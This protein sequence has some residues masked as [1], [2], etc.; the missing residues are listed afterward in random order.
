MRDDPPLRQQATADAESPS[1]KRLL[2]DPKPKQGL[3]PASSASSLSSDSSS[4]RNRKKTR[5]LPNLSDCHSCGVHVNATDPKDR[6]Q[7]LGSVWRIV[8]LCRKCI[9]RVST[10][11]T[12]SYC[13]SEADSECYRCRDCQRRI[14]KECVVRYQCFPPWSYCGLELGF[15]VCV[16]CWVPKSLENSVRVRKRNRNRARVSGSKSMEDIAS[17]AKRAVEKK[18]ADATKA[19][20]NAL[21]KA[22]VARRALEFSN[23][24]LELVAKKDDSGEKNECSVTSCS[25]ASDGT[26]STVA[27]EELAFQLHRAMNSSP[28]ISRKLCLVNSSCLPV[29]G[30]RDCSGKSLVVL[31]GSRGSPNTS[32][33]GTIEEGPSS[34]KSENTDATVS[35][36]SVHVMLSDDSS[37]C[38]GLGH[39]K[40][41]GLVYT[42]KRKKNK[43]YWEKGGGTFGKCSS[44]DIVSVI[45]ESQIWRRQGVLA[46]EL[47]S[48]DTRNQGQ[49]NYCGNVTMLRDRRCNGKLDRYMLKYSKKPAGLKASS[50]T[51]TNF[52]YD[53]GYVESQ[54]Q[55]CHR[56]GALKFNDTRN[57]NQLTGGDG[58]AA[59]LHDGRCNGKLDRYMLKYTKRP[60][61]LKASSR[62]ETKIVYDGFYVESKARA[63]GLTLNCS[64]ERRLLS[65]ASF[66]SRT[67]PLQ[68]SAC[69]SG[70]S[71]DLF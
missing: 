26:D 11:K 18:A 31:S 2:A 47:Y 1:R 69:A 46:D 65:S 38:I 43:E 54:S 19:K 49:R 57:Q 36:P 8:L 27:D 62:N 32:V 56:Q 42:R 60:A 15:S 34:K 24:S 53:D 66:Q 25:S 50:R 12:C 67:V 6:L 48:E 70:L 45:F 5:D 9:S 4:D 41:E 44:S 28:R 64:E 22:V 58:N 23:G 29:P 17:D 59:M 33:S 37:P 51:G 30:V 16:D 63:V 7:T 20:E 3:T 68:A 55:S 35:K 52:R 13:F 21:I 14:H 71:Q 39:L 10:A 61:G 40:Q